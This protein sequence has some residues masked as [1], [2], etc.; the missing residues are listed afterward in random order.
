MPVVS[1]TP[2]VPSAAYRLPVPVE[3]TAFPEH[4]VTD[5]Q[6]DTDA[7]DGRGERD[8]STE[9]ADHDDERV[10]AAISRAWR[11]HPGRHRKDFFTGS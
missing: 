7:Y 5:S 3:L 2:P 6:D 8:E 4:S 1:W 10:D 9:A 11:S